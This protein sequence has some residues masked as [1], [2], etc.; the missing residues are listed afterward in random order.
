MNTSKEQLLEKEYKELET[1]HEQCR[2]AAILFYRLKYAE[3]NLLKQIKF[4]FRPNECY[5]KWAHRAR[6]IARKNLGRTKGKHR[7]VIDHINPLLKEF[8]EGKTP[9]EA[10]RMDNL[11]LLSKKANRQKSYV[12]E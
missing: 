5:K 11:Q 9:E 6:A 12:R 1:I 3:R 4:H 2:E 7:M 10:S 8:L